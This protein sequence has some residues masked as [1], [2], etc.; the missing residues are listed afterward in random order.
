MEQFSSHEFS[1]QLKNLSDDEL[2][3]AWAA[4]MREMHTRKLI[5][6]W[7]NPVADYAERIVALRLN[8]TLAD[9]S[10]Q[11]YDA[12]DSDEQVRYQIKSRRL[13][14]ENPSMQ[15][16]VI[17]KLEDNEF[18]FLIAAI[19]DEDLKLSE[20]WSIPH[21]VIKDFATYVPTLNGH[22]ITLRPPLTSHESV[23]RLP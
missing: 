12:T 20:M 3:P 21:A 2:G 22:R 4:V 14:R 7:N 13:T 11:G 10:A 8:L 18:D 1:H 23:R 19:F 5:R 16:G 15:L 6:S 17:R 9:K